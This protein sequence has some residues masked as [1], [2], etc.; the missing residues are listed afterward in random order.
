MLTNVI[1][2][3]IKEIIKEFEKDLYKLEGKTILITGGNGLIPSYI[4]DT[5]ALFNERLDKPVKI[6][7]MNKN[8]T[9]INSR[10][11]YLLQDPNVHFITH[12]VGKKFDVVGKPNIIIHAASRANPTAFLEDPIDTIDA[13]VNATRIFLDYAKENPIDNFLFFSSAEIYGNPIKEFLPTPEDYAGNATPL[14]KYSCYIESKRFC[15]T[16]CYNYFKKYNIPVKLLRI[17]LTYGPGIRNDGKAVSDFFERAMNEGM[18]TLRDAGEARRS[19][20]YISDAVRAIFQIMFQGNNGEAY[21]IGNDLPSENITIRKL[22]ELIADTVDKNIKVKPN[23]DAP[24]R[25]I[26]GEENRF[27]NINKL[28]GLGFNPKVNI[29]EGLK[30]TKQYYDEKNIQR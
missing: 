1:K 26:Y 25:Q 22:A 13:N 24:K 20:C 30:K 11:G 8:P 15:E 28:R 2:E 18:I 29:V 10:L 4:I 23:F 3:D 27:V 5:I 21:N 16:L 7:V 6:I 9:T 19:F 12:D 14:D 17:L